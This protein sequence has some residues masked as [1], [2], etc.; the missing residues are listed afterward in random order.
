[1]HHYGDYSGPWIENYYIKHFIQKPLAYFSG[2]VPLF[3]Q[4]VDAYLQQDNLLT[5]ILNALDKKLRDDVIYVAI[6]Q[7]DFGMEHNFMKKRPNVLVLSAGGYGHIP[8]PL[9]KGNLSCFPHKNFTDY[10]VDVGF[11][12]EKIK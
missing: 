10:A 1:M 2:M 12:G 5:D 9:V 6:S 7:L 8:L 4:L 3:I 11:Y